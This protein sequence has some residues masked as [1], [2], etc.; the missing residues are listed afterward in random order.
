MRSIIF[1]LSLI[2]LFLFCSKKSPNEPK[3]NPPQANFTVNP[4]SGTIFTIFNFDAS[5]S[6]DE[7]DDSTQLQVRWDWDNDGSWDTEYTTTKTAIHQFKK[8]GI[9]KTKLEVKDTDEATSSISKEIEVIVESPVPLKVGNW[10]KYQD[11]EATSITFEITIDSSVTI[12]GLQGYRAVSVMKSTLFGVVLELKYG[13][14]WDDPLF[15][16]YLYDDSLKTWDR[17]QALAYPSEVDKSTEWGFYETTLIDKNAESNRYEDCYKYK[18]LNLTNQKIFYDIIKPGIGYV[19]LDV[20]GLLQTFN[21]S[22]SLQ[23]SKN[24]FVIKEFHVN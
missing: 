16:K 22:K 2:S 19:D 14:V 9:Y 12:E 21:L 4:I 5:L 23:I 17:F 8:S 6:S 1:F 15:K 7:E 18:L 3:N 11:P 24:K 10:W 20:E 13:W